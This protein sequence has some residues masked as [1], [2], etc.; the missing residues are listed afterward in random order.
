MAKVLAIKTSMME[1][2]SRGS[3]STVA[4]DEWIKFYKEKNPQD[5]VNVI[6]LNTH[7]VGTHVLT[8]E[9]FNEFFATSDEYINQLKTVDK[10]VVATPMTNFNYP[11]PLKNYLD[12]ILVAGKTFKYKYDGKG[13]AEGLLTNLKVL[14]ITSQGAPKGWYPFG[15]H[16]ISLTGTWKFTGATTFKPLIIAGT[17][18]P[19]MRDK[20]ADE[21]VKIYREE[22]KKSAFEF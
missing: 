16:T 18:T 7:K 15:D 1:K 9:N 8:S 5:E 3:I 12:H 21:I 19:E 11:A 6:N 22:I 20:S 10:V 14:L 17:K 13:E 4:L 2:S